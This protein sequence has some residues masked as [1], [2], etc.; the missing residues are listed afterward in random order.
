VVIDLN[1]LTAIQKVSL[2]R[3]IAKRLADAD[4]VG[5]VGE[6]QEEDVGILLLLRNN[7]C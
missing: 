3:D 1:V 4:E 5:M 6:K 2:E 7:N